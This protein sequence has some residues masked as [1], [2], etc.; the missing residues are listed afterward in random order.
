MK[1]KCCLASTLSDILSEILLWHKSRFIRAMNL[2]IKKSLSNRT[3]I[4]YWDEFG[5]GP[6]LFEIILRCIRNSPR[7]SILQCK[8]RLPDIHWKKNFG[9]KRD[10]TTT[11][12]PNFGKVD[13]EDAAD[14]VSSA[15]SSAA[16][17]GNCWRSCALRGLC[18]NNLRK[19]QFVNRKEQGASIAASVGFRWDLDFCDT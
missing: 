10:L 1:L 17:A 11:I 3:L 9:H 19:R 4:Y 5:I 18:C 8:T 2:A 7:L 16:M 12:W 14:S 15:V 13:I 6:V